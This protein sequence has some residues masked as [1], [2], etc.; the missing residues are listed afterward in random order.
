MKQVFIVLVTIFL[1]SH[2]FIRVVKSIKEMG[3]SSSSGSLNL[4]VYP[5]ENRDP[6]LSGYYVAGST[7]R[8]AIYA[9]STEENASQMNS[10]VASLEVYF[11]GKENVKVVYNHTEYYT[12]HKGHRRSRTVK[13]QAYASRDIFRVSIPLIS[14]FNGATGRYE[15]PFEVR[16]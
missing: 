15:Y 10:N 3:N 1:Y 8:G 13:R 9:Y 2:Y 6:A 7:V 14:N 16:T 12:D 5:P 11:A 4:V